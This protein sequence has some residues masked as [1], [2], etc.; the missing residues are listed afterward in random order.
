MRDRVLLFTVS[1]SLGG[2]GAVLGSI[3]G[4]AAGKRGLFAGALVGGLVGASGSSFVARWRGWIRPAQLRST[5]L[6]ATI[7]F[8]VAALIA[9]Q[10][11]RSPIGP[12][13]STSLIGAGALLGARIHR[14]HVV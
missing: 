8:L 12:V 10:T 14:D 1:C 5:A 13:L 2:A 7:G 3:V 9:T 6:G 4:N 11:L